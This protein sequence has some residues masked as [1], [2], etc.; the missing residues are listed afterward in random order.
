MQLQI[1][2]DAPSIDCKA[3][4]DIALSCGN[5]SLID[6]FVNASVDVHGCLQKAIALGSDRVLDLVN[7]SAKTR[8][9]GCQPWSAAWCREQ[10]ENP[11]GANS[12]AH[13]GCVWANACSSNVHREA[14]RYQCQDSEWS[15]MHGHS[16]A[17]PLVQYREYT[18]P[19]GL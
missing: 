1:R 12:L 3:P 7:T 11:G 9:T 6:L 13:Y 19:M 14:C 2:I 15:D 10:C 16:T 4:L 17:K 5:D 18:V 8:I